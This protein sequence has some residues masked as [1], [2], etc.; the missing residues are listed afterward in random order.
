MTWFFI[1]LSAPF[2]W[3]LVNIS[4]QYLVE[5]YSEKGK[6]RSSGG[7]VLFCSFIGVFTAI[8]IGLLTKGVFEISILDKMLLIITGGLTIGWI[9]FYLYTLEIEDV[10]TVVPWF[11]TVPIFGFM[12]GYI[13]LGETLSIQ[14]ILGSLVVLFGV[15]LVSIDY[16]E[17]K[18]KI[19][20]KPVL[21]ML[22]ACLMI[23]ISGVI[24]KFVTIEGNFW[25]SS[26]W[27]YAGLAIFGLGVFVFVPKYR[28][29]FMNMNRKGGIKIF[30]L[31]VFTEIF[32]IAGNLLTN[33]AIL[34]A[35]V[36]MVYLVGS[37]QP[38]ILLILTLLCT[39]FF[40]NIIK[41]NMDRKVLLPKII[42]I[43][44]MIIGSII[45]FV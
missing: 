6:E 16:S 45:L 19:K 36:T 2:L 42:A 21:Y 43:G 10:S 4:D 40:P 18:K 44:I 11:L 38:G 14:Q 32:T 3:A 8:V 7:L 31:N 35:P 9:I 1:A 28:R 13:F 30:I 26:F 37:F 20:W 15:F 41:E 25:V 22:I 29:E 12:F 33:F 5:R 24:F 39:R 23:A 17:Q 27:E 34:L